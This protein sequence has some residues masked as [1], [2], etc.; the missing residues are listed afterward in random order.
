VDKYK[1]QEMYNMRHHTAA[2]AAAIIIINISHWQL[3]NELAASAAI[4]PI[5]HLERVKADASSLPG[6]YWQSFWTH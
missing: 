6:C 3:P 4:T 1:Y 5:V 2:V